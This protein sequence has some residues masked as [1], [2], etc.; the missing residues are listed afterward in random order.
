MNEPKITHS[1][2]LVPDI[3]A[4]L[5]GLRENESE[6]WDQFRQGSETAFITIYDRY[7]DKLVQYGNQLSGKPALTED[8]IQDIFIRIRQKR[9]GLGETNS[10]CFYLMKCLK[11]KLIR[12]MSKTRNTTQFNYSEQFLITYSHEQTLIDRQIHEEQAWLLNNALKQLSGRKKEA[13]YYFY[14][15]GLSYPQISELMGLSHVK[16]ARNLVYQAITSLKKAIDY[17]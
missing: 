2:P 11:R 4:P 8:C 10:I 16:S 9:N 5:P 13:L 7:F 3:P 15:E 1:F 6:L 17:K 14:F 12:E